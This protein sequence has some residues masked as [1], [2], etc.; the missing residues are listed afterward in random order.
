MEVYNTVLTRLAIIWSIISKSVWKRWYVHVFKQLVQIPAVSILIFSYELKN[1]LD[2]QG[3]LF[4]SFINV[5]C[6]IVHHCLHIIMYK[7]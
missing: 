3:V 5:M 1:P 6:I 2:Y 7:C 4:C